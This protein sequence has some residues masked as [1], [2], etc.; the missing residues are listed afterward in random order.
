MEHTD[1][2]DIVGRL[3]NNFALMQETLDEH[4]GKL[5]DIN[6]EREQ[7][8][9]ELIMA[10]ER[11]AEA[12]RQ[13]EAFLQD[14]S[15]QIRTPLNIIVGFA[16]VLRDNYQMVSGEEA[17]SI[18]DTMQRSAISVNR[19]VNMLVAA[20]H[21]ADGR[22]RTEFCDVVS[23]EQLASHVATI[24]NDCPPRNIPLTLDVKLPR[25][26]TI[27]TNSDYLTKALNEVLY[28]A[29]KFTVRGTI[30]LRLR[31][32]GGVVRFIVED[33]GP[34]I[35][36]ESRDRIFTHFHKIDDFGEGLGL[37]LSISRQFARMLGGDLYL[38]S[39]YTAGARF[40]LE[41]PAASSWHNNAITQ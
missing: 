3:Q 16:Q 27:R 8:N 20:A 39:S 25:G 28:N 14:M 11:A 5:R 29:K 35:P 41:V 36:E 19:M 9:R 4:I 33:T 22:V 2:S 15:H 30:T 37:G 12:A 24:F 34:G 6:A 26:L 38:D 1:R 23:P 31:A 18:T 7:R 32:E 21:V 40:V 17:E 13:K 10:N